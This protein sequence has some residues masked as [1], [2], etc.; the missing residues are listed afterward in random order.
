MPRSQYRRLRGLANHRQQ[1]LDFVGY[2]SIRRFRRDNPGYATPDVAYRDI[3]NLYNEQ[4]DNLRE[5]E[6]LEERARRQQ[7]TIRNR[8]DRLLGRRITRM[9]DTPSNLEQTLDIDMNVLGNIRPVLNRLVGTQRRFYLRN[10]PQIYMLNANTIRRL[11]DIIDNRVDVASVEYESGR[12]IITSITEAGDVSLVLLPENIE[13]NQQVEGGLF[14]YTHNLDKVDLRKYAIYHKDTKWGDELNDNNC[15]ITALKSAGVETG[16]V[17]QFV[18]NQFIPQKCLGDIASKIDKYIVVKSLTGKRC[19]RKYGNPKNETI[20][21]GLIEK[22]YFL[23]E[24]TEYTSYSIINYFDINDKPRWNEI[25]K[26]RDGYIKC[27][28]SR[29]IDSYTLI[30]LLLKNKDTHLNNLEGVEIYKMNNFK[31]FEEDIFK[32]L[33]YVNKI[34]E[35]RFNKKTYQLEELNPDGELEKNEPK[36]KSEKRVVLGLDYFDFETTTKRDDGIQVNNHYKDASGNLIIHKPYCV[37]SCETAKYGGFWGDNCGKKFLEY[38]C[39]KYGEMISDDDYEPDLDMRKLFVLIAHNSGYD[40]RFL[41]EHFTTITTIEKGTG[42]MIAVCD[43]YMNRYV[44]KKKD[45]QKINI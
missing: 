9:V 11:E 22:H 23:I 44:G 45:Y 33:S 18:K 28:K 15:L 10:G 30:D 27:D 40:F 42:L 4:I 12:E 43:F 16:A 29:F 25:Y 32:D 6:R 14:L 19:L 21:I 35:Y 13:G 17:E 20:N 31:K 24:P 36:H 2:R 39:D 5:Q 3:L 1:L 41:Q 8:Y 38:Y 34:H 7:Q 37:Y 26:I